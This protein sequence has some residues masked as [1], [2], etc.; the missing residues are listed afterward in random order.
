MLDKEKGEFNFN[1]FEDANSKLQY[2]SRY[3]GEK[4]QAVRGLEYEIVSIKKLTKRQRKNRRQ[5]AK[6]K[7]TKALTQTSIGLEDCRGHG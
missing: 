4:S 7:N 5:W 2:Q 6:M 3:A 1:M